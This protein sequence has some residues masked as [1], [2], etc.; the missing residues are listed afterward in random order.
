[1]LFDRA[2]LVRT[3][4][5]IAMFCEGPYSGGAVATQ[6]EPLKTILTTNE[7]AKAM[8][9]RLEQI[10][11]I[12]HDMV[13]QYGDPKGEHKPWPRTG[14]TR[15]ATQAALAIAVGPDTEKRTPWQLTLDWWQNK[16]GDEEENARARCCGREMQHALIAAGRRA[17]TA[18]KRKWAFEAMGIPAEWLQKEQP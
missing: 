14:G 8:K 2:N 1:L 13:G 12:A 4:W 7:E 9:G 16:Y 15:G 17:P 10:K 18:N 6:L 3:F 11:G 5:F